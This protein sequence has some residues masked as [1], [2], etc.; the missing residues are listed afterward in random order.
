MFKTHTSLFLKKLKLQTNEQT[1]AQEVYIYQRRIE[2]NIYS[3]VIIR[4][5]VAL[6]SSKLTDFLKNLNQQHLMK[7]NK[8]I[9]YLCD[10]KYLTICYSDTINKIFQIFNDTAFND[11]L[12]IRHSIQNYFL[13]LFDKFI[14]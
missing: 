6:T 11:N 5:D 1:S 10:S 4:F 14:N 13:T 3:S 2:F 8:K 7:V 12:Q 9:C